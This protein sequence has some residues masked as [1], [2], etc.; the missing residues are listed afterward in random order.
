MDNKI[1]LPTDNIYK[2][3]SMFGLLLL[4]FGFGSIIYLNKVTNNLVFESLIELENLNSIQQK[5]ALE[6]AQEKVVLRK[7]ELATKDKKSFIN[8]L[9]LM[10][11]GGSIMMIYGFL[12]WHTKVQPIQDEISKLTLEKLR[13][14]VETM[15]D[16]ENKG[17]L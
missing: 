13:Y 1:P 9:H 12:K 5:S 8:L 2:F 4:I 17:D 11:M 3:Y 16:K 14:E 6:D 10:I 7:V 15:K